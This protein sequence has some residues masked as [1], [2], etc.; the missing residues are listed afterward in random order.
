M[1]NGMPE[2][3]RAASAEG[4]PT[5]AH[6]DRYCYFVA[7]V[8]GEMLSAMFTDYEPGMGEHDAELNRLAVSFGQGL[9]MTNILKDIWA[10]HARGVCWLPRDVFARHGFDLSDLGKRRTD[11]A[12]AAGLVR[13]DRARDRPSAQCAGVHPPHP[14]ASRK[15]CAASVCGRSGWRC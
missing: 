15:V 12:F 5:L 14:R 4:L 10:D 13:A 8:V 2:Y 1:C 3:E 7:G 11:E 6:L 9:Q